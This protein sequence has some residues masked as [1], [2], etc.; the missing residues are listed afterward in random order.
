MTYFALQKHPF[1]LP[2]QNSSELRCCFT[3]SSDTSKCLCTM[4][5][6]T[7]LIYFL[8]IQ[9][10]PLL[11]SLSSYKFI[12]KNS[13][14]KSQILYIFQ[15]LLDTEHFGSS[16]IPTTLD[17]WNLPFLKFINLWVGWLCSVC[18]VNLNCFCKVLITSLWNVLHAVVFLSPSVVYSHIS[19]V[20]FGPQHHKIALPSA[21]NGF[22]HWIHPFLMWSLA[23]LS[24]LKCKEKSQEFQKHYCHKLHFWCYPLLQIRVEIPFKYLKRWVF[25]STCHW[26]VLT[27]IKHLTFTLF[28]LLSAWIYIYI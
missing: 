6:T 4:Q 8:Q 14:L 11:W 3:P 15:C 26:P 12:F 13:S 20:H 5:S 28:H 7:V 1:I 22:N 24:S 9:V 10:L 2:M 18:L 19:I 21:L 25:F 16:V 27:S 23:F 17:V